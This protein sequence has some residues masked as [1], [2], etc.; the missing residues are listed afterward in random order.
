MTN[1][2]SILSGPVLDEDAYF[3]TAELCRSC[4]VNA[5][6]VLEMVG[7][8]IIDPRGA[9]MREWRFSFTAVRRVRTAVHLVRDLNVNLAGAA[10]ALELMEEL[11][12]LRREVALR[13]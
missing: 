7:E 12:A 9:T 11:D 10:L 2:D 13:Q 3:T 5:E 1:N 4:G 8:G 6:T